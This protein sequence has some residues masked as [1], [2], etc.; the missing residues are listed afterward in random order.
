MANEDRQT[1]IRSKTV[2]SSIKYAAII[3]LV[4]AFISLPAAASVS[5][6]ASTPQIITRGETFS[7]TGTIPGHGPVAIWIIGRGY[8]DSH[9]VIPDEKGRFIY[10]LS[11]RETQ[12]LPVGQCAF[13]IQEP[14]A[15]G[16]L[17]IEYQ[18]KANGNITLLYKGKTFSDIGPLDNIR[19]TVVPVISSLSSAERPHADDNF[20][21]NYLLVEDPMVYFDQV[22]SP[23][24][25]R[26]LGQISGNSVVFTGT[27]NL[28]TH[29]TLRAS[30]HEA[31][32]DAVITAKRIPVTAG[33]ELNH[34]SYTLESPGLPAGDYRLT[35]SPEDPPAT[36]LRS[37]AFSVTKNAVVSSTPEGTPA[38][39][40]SPQWFD[41]TIPLF[42]V[43]G[44]L[45]VLGLLVFATW[46][47]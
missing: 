4:L 2:K 16:L 25:N 39:P 6:A 20:T 45:I 30:I 12:Q 15:N 17:D 14:G 35:I 8:I 42:V 46:Q 47:K 36:G 23:G 41:P 33:S 44:L 3:L 38:L 43:V 19:A 31:A 21:A 27:T 28:G 10:K 24:E 9:V 40:R 34:W 26:L 22:T 37:A 18:K 32:T 29:V 1:K 13:V 5:F 11:A 7:L